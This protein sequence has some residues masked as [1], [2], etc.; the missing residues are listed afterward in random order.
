M[1]GRTQTGEE[2]GLYIWQVKTMLDKDQ[3]PLVTFIRHK[4]RSRGSEISQPAFR[5]LLAVSYRQLIVISGL[6]FLSF[7]METLWTQPLENLQIV[8]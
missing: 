4:I 2:N 8:R 5:S 3:S 7:Q 6:R 1:T